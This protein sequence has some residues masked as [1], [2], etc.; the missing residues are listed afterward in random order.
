MNR[1]KK[2]YINSTVALGSQLL[3]IILSF[4]VRKIF[5]LTLGMSYLGYNSVFSNILQM[6][7]LADL[8]IGVAVT[9]FL[10]KPLAENDKKRIAA[11]MSLYKRIYN[12]MGFVV[13]IIGLIVSIF[14]DQIIPDSSVSP[15]YLRILFYINLTGTVST[16]FLAYKRTLIIADQKSYI[17]NIT[18]TITY[19]V[20]TIM[21]IASLFIFPSYI[22]FLSLNIAKNII[23]NLLLSVHCDKLYGKILNN[24]DRE[25]Y[26]E[27]KPQIIRYVKDVFISRIG[28]VVFYGTDNVIISVFRG[29]LLAGYLSNYTMITVHLTTI[30]NQLL[31]SIQAT[32]GNFINS[33]KT[34]A[35]QKRMTDY[36]LCANYFIGNFCMVCFTLLAQPF[37]ERYF[38]KTLMLSF[39]TA[40]WLGINL[41]LQI[42]MQ[43]PSQ[44]F[45]IY[46]LFRYDRPI[47]IISAILNITI[48]ALLVKSLGVN[49]V[50]IGTFVTSLIYL[51]SRFYIISK[52]V[53]KVSYLSYLKKL[54][55]YFAL[56]LAD[57]CLAYYVVRGIPGTTWLNFFVRA[58]LIASLAILF[59][60]FVLSFTSEFKYL[61]NKMLPDKLSRYIKPVFLGTMVVLVMGVALV[62]GGGTR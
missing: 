18:D 62:A 50:L 51:F 8:G 25:L 21:Q 20:M 27:Y 59:S 29:S 31:S 34:I 55:F 24:P 32:F 23:S 46:K 53:Y 13:L 44:V 14:L 60:G 48:S 1:A 17:T 5:I 57:I 9:S 28:A 58:I 19:F 35:E 42:L 43:L 7:N 26:D 61:V 41:L 33:G 54:F 49:G 6:L 38:G 56:S 37:I 40:I 30:T 15:L 22:V 39:T 12:I 16:Y 3:Q 2:I 4:V 47:I 36:Y 45:T 10:Y 11:L 52:Y